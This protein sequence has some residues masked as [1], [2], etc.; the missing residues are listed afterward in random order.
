M[1]KLSRKRIL[2]NV[3][4]EPDEIDVPNDSMLILK[5]LKGMSYCLSKICGTYALMDFLYQFKKVTTKEFG[6]DSEEEFRLKIA[7]LLRESYNYILHNEFADIKSHISMTSGNI[8]NDNHIIMFK[9]TKRN[10][11]MQIISSKSIR[12]I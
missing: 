5:W 4:S 12:M 10:T 6:K 3:K 2:C 7:I 8:S 11:L 9:E 1:S